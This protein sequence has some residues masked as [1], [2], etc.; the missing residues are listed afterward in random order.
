[1]DSHASPP[2][3]PLTCH[4]NDVAYSVTGHF[5]QDPFWP[6][7]T[8]TFRPKAWTFLLTKKYRRFGQ[9]VFNMFTESDIIGRGVTE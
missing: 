5:G 3:Q 6:Q 2:T 4:V 9:N 7:K 8:W 1:M